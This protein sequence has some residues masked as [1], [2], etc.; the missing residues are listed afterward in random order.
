MNW[1]DGVILAA[2]IAF[3]L[4][5]YWRGLLQSLVLLVLF[6]ASLAV[7]SRTGESVGDIFSPL[8]DS[9]DIQTLA[10]L[11][12]IFLSFIIVIFALSL[13]LT[14]LRPLWRH[15]LAFKLNRLAGAVL[16]IG[17]AL[18]TM[19]GLLTAS[20]HIPVNNL[21]QDIDDS[22]LGSFVADT[23]DELARL[24]RIIPGGWSEISD[25]RN[26]D[27]LADPPP[28]YQPPS[29]PTDL[30]HLA[31]YYAPVVFMDTTSPTPKADYLTGWDYDSD[32]DPLN[33][34][35]NLNRGD[36]DL[37]GRVYYWV[38]E[39]QSHWFIGYGFFHPRD[40]GEAGVIQC[41]AN[42]DVTRLGCHE[43]DMEGALIAVQ[44]SSESAYGD[45]LTMETISHSGILSFKDYQRSPSSQI[46]GHFPL[47]NN[48]VCDVEFLDGTSHPFVYI[49]AKSHAV[50]GAIRSGPRWEQNFPGGDG[51]L[52][53]PTGV[54]QVPV[55]GDDRRGAYE[56]V[57]IVTLWELR[58]DDSIFTTETTGTGGKFLGDDGAANTASPPWR[59]ADPDRPD[60]GPG[61]LFLDPALW[62]NVVHDGAVPWPMKYVARSYDLA[63]EAPSLNANFDW[64][65][66]ARFGTDS[67]GDALIDYF[68]NPDSVS[69]AGW[70]VNLNACA[71]SA[72][73]GAI[74]E[75]VWSVDG[76]Q[77]GS[78]SSCDG[79]SYEFPSEGA[80][81]VTL[82]VSSEA[83]ETAEQT[84]ELV[85]QD[86]LIVSL[87]DSYASGQG[88]PDIPI[89]LQAGHWAPG[90]E[91]GT[92]VCFMDETETL[93]GI[94]DPPDGT[95]DSGARCLALSTPGTPL[96]AT[97]QEASCNRSAHA[98]PVQAAILLEK[99][100]PRT[101]VTLLHFACSGDQ[102]PDLPSQI[103]AANKLIGDR[104]VDAVVISIGGNDARFSD[105]IRM[106]INQ[107]PCNDE[108]FTLTVDLTGCEFAK[109][110]NKYAECVDFISEFGGNPGSPNA[111]R[112]F[113]E[114]VY[115]EG[116][117]APGPGCRRLLDLF[118][119]FRDQELTK[120]RGLGVPGSTIQDPKR[121]YL[122]EY[123]SVT[124][125]G[126]GGFCPADAL[127]VLPGWSGVELEWADTVVAPQ[128]NQLVSQAAQEAGWNLIS[129][130]YD[131]FSTHGLC[132]REHWIVR[133]RESFLAQGDP[134]G[135]I[136]P[137]RM[138]NAYYGRRITEA[139]RTDFYEDGDLD[140]PRRPH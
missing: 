73:G 93:P 117:S 58:N 65:M 41:T 121:V 107:E 17:A 61:V 92:G 55:S 84:S 118:A 128:L 81:Q 96:V 8:T 56:L 7:S 33:N 131:G 45:F 40:W 48:R 87:G 10:G 67:D 109:P 13:I 69:P 112:L 104:E 34:W 114:A 140:L 126:S 22:F 31:E 52:Y 132:A 78:R 62:M 50:S 86:W 95:R 100:D 102:I 66:P 80:Y 74:S 83:G 98:G 60:T 38:L 29:S 27:A 14:K 133:L 64:S 44:R 106:C 9:E 130:I 63:G 2:G 125:D 16:M 139:L 23:V 20:Q 75:Y 35:N 101:S 134:S 99:G 97:W 36:V 129:G 79:F 1:I 135:S 49:E 37:R 123:P 42:Q 120:L 71:S 15:T 137:N 4:F 12:I 54:G 59:W 122:T 110:L 76:V 47:C 119:A 25:N 26:R 91:P 127:N 24:I 115:N 70:P 116:C 94:V 89:G 138:G 72:P 77:Q 30:R 11:G 3:A 88:V 113:F 85:V 82:T 28:L 57:D 53:F 51:V 21:E 19:V 43:N 68:N 32:L 90:T 111:Q 5:G 108:N 103:E 105:I 39:T 6:G 124:R 18:V 136:H 46:S